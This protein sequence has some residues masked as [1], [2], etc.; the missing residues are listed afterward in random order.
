MYLTF[1][2][3]HY[4]CKIHPYCQVKLKSLLTLL[5]CLPKKLSIVTLTQQKWPTLTPS[6]PSLEA[7]WLLA[8][9]V[10][11]LLNGVR[12]LQLWVLA[13]ITVKWKQ[14]NSGS[15]SWKERPA[16]IS[17]FVV[18]K[19]R[20][21][22]RHLL[23]FPRFWQKEVVEL[24]TSVGHVRTGDQTHLYLW[25]GGGWGCCWEKRRGE[26][27]VQVQGREGEATEGPNTQRI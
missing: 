21:E 12:F 27:S 5:W 6:S 11:H 23:S 14:E 13:R 17:G 9:T 4:V 3:Q 22:R 24:G 8:F 7:S 19:Q 10:V 2:P 15:L 18:N 1:F 16:T 20:N 26:D 25:E